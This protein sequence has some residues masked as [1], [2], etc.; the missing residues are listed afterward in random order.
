MNIR[1]A[2]G[3]LSA[4][5]ALSLGGIGLF[6]DRKSE[7]TVVDTTDP[8]PITYTPKPAET[9]PLYKPNSTP[10]PAKNNAS[11]EDLEKLSQTLDEINAR[12]DR[13]NLEKIQPPS[14]NQSQSMETKMVEALGY[15]SVKEKQDRLRALISSYICSLPDGVIIDGSNV[16]G[17]QAYGVKAAPPTIVMRYWTD[18]L[19]SLDR[20]YEL[21]GGDT[22]FYELK[23]AFPV[24]ARGAFNLKPSPPMT[25]T[26]ATIV[27]EEDK[28]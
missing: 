8:Q 25:E 5:V 16:Y 17:S 21:M 2:I 6:S 27:C 4:A 28:K 19:E 15:G 7:S 14:D 20:L 18:P 1:Y 13:I 11:L 22:D 24:Y 26:I 12:L 10:N 3:G 23:S 9:T